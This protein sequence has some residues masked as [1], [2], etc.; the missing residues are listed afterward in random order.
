MKKPLSTTQPKEIV[1]D[2]ELCC[3]FCGKNDRQHDMTCTTGKT[4]MGQKL[5][6]AYHKSCQREYRRELRERK[7]ARFI[8]EFDDVD[9]EVDEETK[10]VNAIWQ[11]LINNA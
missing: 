6:R 4:S 3:Q 1:P 11:K 9:V 7:T 5:R 8:V 2:S 10:R